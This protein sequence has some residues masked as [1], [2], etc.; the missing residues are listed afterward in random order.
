MPRFIVAQNRNGISSTNNFTLNTFS[1]TSVRT[2]IVIPEFC[3]V[4]LLLSLTRDC[5]LFQV[6]RRVQERRLL[7]NSLRKL[8]KIYH[9]IQNVTNC[10]KFLWTGDKLIQ[11][12]FLLAVIR[13]LH[14]K[15]PL[16]V[17]PMR[18]A[19]IVTLKTLPFPRHFQISAMLMGQIKIMIC[20]H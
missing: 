15:T 6:K 14:L 20:H 17:A 18:L 13:P 3:A 12:A 1:T 2:Q 8:I 19:L 4:S 9:Y 5:N 7:Q 16:V 10:F 11:K